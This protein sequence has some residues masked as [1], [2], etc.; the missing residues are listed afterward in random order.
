MQASNA[1]P[2]AAGYATDIDKIANQQIISLIKSEFAGHALAELVPG[3][4][5][6]RGLYAKGLTARTRWRCRYPRSRRRMRLGQMPDLRKALSRDLADETRAKL[7]LNQIGA[8][9]S[10]DEA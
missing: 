2:E 4:P 5:A 7:P 6:C 10:G 3:N 9:I 8:P 1:E